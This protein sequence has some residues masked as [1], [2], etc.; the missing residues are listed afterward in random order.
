MTNIYYITFQKENYQQA[1]ADLQKMFEKALLSAFP[2]RRYV[3]SSWRDFFYRFLMRFSPVW[4]QERLALKFMRIPN[5]QGKP[6]LLI[7]TQPTS[8]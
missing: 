8:I 7:P 5:W 1:N 2:Q 3:N 6:F 4:L